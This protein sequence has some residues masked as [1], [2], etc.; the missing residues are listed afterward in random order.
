MA[1]SKKSQSKHDT[2]V[3]R[4]AEDLKAQG[5]RVDADLKGF[6]KPDTISGVRPDIL[7]KKGKQKK[8]IEVET[9]DSVDNARDKKQQQTFRQ[10]ASRSQNTTFRRKTTGK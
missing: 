6:P 3:R 9:P 5:Y 1:R 10:A 8:I 7:A 4:I 2:E